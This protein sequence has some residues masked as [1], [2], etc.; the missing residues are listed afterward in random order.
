MITSIA[1]TVYPVREM[2][3]SRRFYENV[4]IPFI[5]GSVTLLVILFGLGAILL[6]DRGLYVAAR[7]TEIV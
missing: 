1:F 3:R 4:V 5:G 7:E 6:A 2:A